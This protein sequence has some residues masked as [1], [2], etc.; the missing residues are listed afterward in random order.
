MHFFE[1][2][3]AGIKDRGRQSKGRQVT[4][5]TLEGLV[6]VRGA[7]GEWLLD[8]GAGGN[9]YWMEWLELTAGVAGGEDLSA[10]VE[11]LNDP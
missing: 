7:G 11:V 1:R 2:H 9:G 4:V 3:D 5:K 6:E 8:G 10:G